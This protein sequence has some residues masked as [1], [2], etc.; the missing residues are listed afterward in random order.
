MDQPTPVLEGVHVLV[1]D[2][3]P[4]ARDLVE[5]ILAQYG[6]DVRTAAS[7]AEALEVLD[8]SLPDVLISDIGMSEEDGYSL[9]RKVRAREASRGGRI[10]A[11][12]LT[13]WGRAE[14]RRQA[15]SAGF[16]THLPKPADPE[17]LARVVDNLS[18]G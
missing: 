8:Q 14:D 7:A 15:L 4:D 18:H 12:A 13:A 16:Q 17:E 5:F 10:P 9:I 2:D 1:V 6:A 11:L 3:D